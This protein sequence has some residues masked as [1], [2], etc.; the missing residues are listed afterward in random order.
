[1]NTDVTTLS[2]LW[3]IRN[4]AAATLALC[5]EQTERAV[6]E[7]S[8]EQLDESIESIA[9]QIG[10]IDEIIRSGRLIKRRGEKVVSSG[11]RLRETLDREVAALQQHVKALR[12]E[13]R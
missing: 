3:R 1:M 12:K 9:N 4:A 10:L 11:E 13:G 2:D 8:L 5:E 7:A 6:R